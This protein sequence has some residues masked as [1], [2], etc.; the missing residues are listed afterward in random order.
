MSLVFMLI[1]YGEYFDIDMCHIFYNIFP[2]LYKD[3]ERLWFLLV[4]QG[5]EKVHLVCKHACKIFPKD[6]K[7]RVSLSKVRIV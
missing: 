2:I 5:N 7:L 4:L 1:M 6:S 3:C